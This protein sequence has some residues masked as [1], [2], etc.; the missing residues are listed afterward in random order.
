MASDASKIPTI[1]GDLAHHHRSTGAA[2][3][4]G[5]G[6]SSRSHV[7]VETNLQ[8]IVF[9]QRPH[10]AEANRPKAAHRSP[11]SALFNFF[12][13]SAV[14]FAR[15]DRSSRPP[16]FNLLGKPIDEKLLKNRRRLAYIRK[17]QFLTHNFLE[18]PDSKS[19]VSYHILQ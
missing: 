19:A 10:A 5:P 8:K 6:A 1:T 3:V 4:G 18:R 9:M 14:S 7:R 16:R 12:P 17:V 2:P 11:A 15:R 13:S